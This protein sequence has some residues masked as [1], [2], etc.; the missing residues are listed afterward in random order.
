[1]NLKNFTQGLFLFF[2]FIFVLGFII[3]GSQFLLAQNRYSALSDISN[4][5]LNVKNSV[6]LN[7][8]FPQRDW[9][10]PDLKINARSGIS[11]ETNLS[12][13]PKLLFS[14]NSDLKLPIASLTKLVTAMIVIDKYDLSEKLTVNKLA[15][16]QAPM[17]R[18]L[19]FG[20]VLTV[21]GLLDIMLI[22]SS[23]KAAFTLS[24]KIGTQNFVDLMNQKVSAIGLTNT[25]F[26]DPSGIS[27][28]NSST[29]YDLAILA[30][31]ILRSYPKIVDI[32]RIQELD[33]P[34]FGRVS[35]TNQML[36][37]IP[38]VIGGKTG[39]TTAAR[40]CLLLVVKNAEMDDYLIYVVL[41]SEDRFMEIKNIIDWTNVSYK[42]K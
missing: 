14:K 23:N 10:I 22:E 40:G 12:E 15:D 34:G 28:R 13:S 8:V 19:K 17:I 1:M 26:E 29:S 18:D 5:I 33:V 6:G 3:F 27:E 36:G 9:N 21:E 37:Q 11:M 30:E 24:E 20:D 39:F 35:N 32:S 2:V 31:Y 42:W 38:E 25:Y 41:G 4:G 16:K 7:G